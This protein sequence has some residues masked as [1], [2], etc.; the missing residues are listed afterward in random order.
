MWSVQTPKK[1]KH[2]R[3]KVKMA[4]LKYYK[5]ESDGK[6]K[7]LR[8]ECPT[9]GAAV[10]VCTFIPNLRTPRWH[11]DFVDV[12]P[13]RSPVL[14]QV[15]FDVHIP[16]RYQT[17]CSVVHLAVAVSRNAN[18]YHFHDELR[19]KIW[20]NGSAFYI[21]YT[22]F[23]SHYS[24]NERSALQRSA[25]SCY[26]DNTN[27]HGQAHHAWMMAWKKYA[28]LYYTQILRSC[29]FSRSWGAT[30]SELCSWNVV[31]AVGIT[32]ENQ[33]REISITRRSTRKYC[34]KR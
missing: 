25:L 16:A 7:R 30:F 22:L 8:R 29:P 6:I 32:S 27:R 2:K 18:Y 14:W 28:R 13:W 9:C 34:T 4:I 3:K 23:W 20:P 17:S 26:W 31:D 12:V 1:I 15:R 19:L 21:L 33:T 5:V 24:I 11:S 10:F